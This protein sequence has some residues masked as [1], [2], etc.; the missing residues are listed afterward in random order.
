MDDD[1]KTLL[2]IL[3]LVYGSSNGIGL[4]KDALDPV[5]EKRDQLASQMR[6]DAA[7]GVLKEDAVKLLKSLWSPFVLIHVLMV[8]IVPTF[9]LLVANYGPIAVLAYIGLAQTPTE[10]S[11]P[12]PATFYWILFGLSL[13]A[14]AHYLSK[15]VKA[16]WALIKYLR[17]K[18]PVGA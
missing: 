11:N 6:A 5:D 17:F 7:P 14:T 9:L 15:Y 12:R 4:L 16:W 13:V 3:A 2:A 8:I 10:S 18:S 1:V